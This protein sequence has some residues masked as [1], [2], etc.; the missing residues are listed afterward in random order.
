MNANVSARMA[1]AF[2]EDALAL[3]SWCEANG[4][5]ED[6]RN[7]RAFAERVEPMT[8]PLRNRWSERGRAA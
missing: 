6:A 1:L 5:P 2:R 4:F 8:S 3:A 7:M